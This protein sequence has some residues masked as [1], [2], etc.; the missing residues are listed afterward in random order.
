MKPNLNFNREIKG[1]G[2]RERERQRQRQR[3]RQTEKERER[4][5]RNLYFNQ[6]FAYIQFNICG[7][8]LVPCS[9]CLLVSGAISSC[10]ST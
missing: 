3:Q 7:R 5:I 4:V 9:E 10:C 8:V 2:E 1:E 6:S